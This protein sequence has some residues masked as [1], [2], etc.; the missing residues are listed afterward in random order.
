VLFN[1]SFSATNEKEGSEIARQIVTALGS[2]SFKLSAG[3]PSQTSYGIDLYR[4]I[5][6]E[7]LVQKI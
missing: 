7:D 3:E 6:H 1:E 5:F 4:K 2:R